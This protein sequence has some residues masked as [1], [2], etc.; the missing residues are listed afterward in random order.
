MPSESGGYNYIIVKYKICRIEAHAIS[1]A[2]KIYFFHP[3][4]LV[5][6]R[7]TLCGYNN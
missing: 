3:L 4:K 1:A 5:A 6:S 2:K 7:T